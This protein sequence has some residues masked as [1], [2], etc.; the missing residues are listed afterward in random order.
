MKENIRILITGGSGFIG[1]NLVE[2]YLTKGVTVLSIDKKRP[3]KA[4]HETV[5]RQVDILDLEALEI[6][7]NA[8]KPTH[9]LH[10]AARTDLDERNHIEGYAA[11]IQGQKNILLM[12]DQCLSVQRVI[13]TSSMLVCRS[14]YNPKS[15]DDYAPSN[16]YGESKVAGE[17]IIKEWNTSR[18]EWLIVRP[19][20]IWGPWFGTP[21]RDFFKRIKNKTYFKISGKSA[22]KI[23]GF[24]GNTVYQ[25]DQLLFLKK[26]MVN[27][28]T[29][30]LG[31]QPPLNVNEWADKIAAQL[32]MKMLTLPLF[33]LKVAGFVGDCLA[34]FHIKFPLTSFRVKNMTSNNAIDLLQDTHNLIAQQPY[35]VE[36]GIKLTLDWMEDN[37]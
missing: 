16:L 31:D 21:Y 12:L 22:T 24:I 17:K 14:G 30:Y 35:S 26:E 8:F 32:N 11:N 19:T 33:V 7:A 4:E 13:F 23:F 10:L 3:M 2:H 15:Y 37:P 36:Q 18:Y 1:T 6:I 28:K 5:W 25:F 27:T 9:V 20:S 29:F 34:I